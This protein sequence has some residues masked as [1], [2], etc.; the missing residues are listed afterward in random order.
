MNHKSTAEF[1]KLFALPAKSTQFRPAIK[2]SKIQAET[3]GSHRPIMSKPVVHQ[4][5]RGS[6]LSSTSRAHDW[7]DTKVKAPVKAAPFFEDQFGRKVHLRGVNM[8]GHSKLPTAPI[9]VS[10]HVQTPEYFN[11]RDVSFVGRP[12]PLEEADDHFCRIKSWGLSFVRLLVTWEALEHKGPGLYDEEFIDYLIA[13]LKKADKHGIKCFI[14]PHQDTWSRFS[15]GSGAPGWTFEVAGMDITA[16]KEVGAAHVHNFHEDAKNPHQY[17]PTNYAKL[18]CAT[19]FTL[20][21]GGEIFAPNATYNGV[22]VCTF[23]Q[24]AYVD[25][26]AHLAKRLQGCNAVVGFEL[27]NEPHYGYIGLKD[28]DHFDPNLFL[29]Y[30]KFAS[31]VQSFG[32]G[33]GMAVEVDYYVNSWPVPTKKAGTR[34]MNEEKRSV[35]LKYGECIWKQHGV[36]DDVNGKPKILKP[37]YFCTHPATGKP[38]DFYDDCYMPM[39]RKYTAAIQKVNQDHLVFFEPIPNE[40]PPVLTEEDRAHPNLVY[41]PHWYDLKTLWEKAFDEQLTFDVQALARGTKTVLTA[42][43]FGRSGAEKNYT[44]QMRNIMQTGK[45]KVG[46]RPVVMGEVGI[47][48]DINE[49]K[50]YETG[51]YTQHNVF[52]DTVISSMETNLFNFTLWNYNPGNDNTHG[53]HWN[54][55]DFSIFSPNSFKTPT[56]KGTPRIINSPNFTETAPLPPSS[57][58]KQHAGM[59]TPPESP[60]AAAERRLSVVADDHIP[61]S[62]FEI[63]GYSYVNEPL[64]GDPD[65]SHHVGGRALDAAIRPYAAKIAGTPSLSKFNLSL[66]TYTLEFKTRY[67]SASPSIAQLWET[68]GPQIEYTTEVFIPNFHFKAEGVTVRVEVSD[69]E[70]KYDQEKQTLLWHYDPSYKGTGSGSIVTHRLVVSVPGVVPPKKKSV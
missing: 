20:F 57:P 66:L 9:T 17:W 2:G 44:G 58:A 4:S 64:E 56:P 10:T 23:L 6:I 29:H 49:K 8:C 15:G 11:H 42:M 36:W 53:D 16:F 33:S 67:D 60:K 34:I 7:R 3:R 41:A 51:D 37:N 47:P 19:M 43:Y 26:Y 70:W 5:E 21:F 27:M 69:G 35:W 32:L 59:I 18:A 62:P 45:V 30:G 25:C 22:N 52:L 24:N 55:E 1:Y 50:A 46:N 48:M 68:K 65:H 28:L 31:P 40:D 54:G 39:M 12:F 61:T 14:D 38:I 13:I 63:T